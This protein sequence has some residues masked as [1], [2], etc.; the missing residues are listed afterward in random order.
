MY[1][2]HKQKRE[3]RKAIDIDGMLKRVKQRAVELNQCAERILTEK[4][5]QTHKT[6][7]Q[8]QTE[9]HVVRST[10]VDIKVTAEDILDSAKQTG[11][12][13]RFLGV[14]ANQ[15][16]R[17]F[18]TNMRGQSN[19]LDRLGQRLEQDLQAI[20][21]ESK[22]LMDSVTAQNLVLKAFADV[23]NGRLHPAMLLVATVA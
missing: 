9:L 12:D 3:R 11:S 4:T 5:L 2:R 17:N 20:N 15:F 7:G 14:A 1:E 22:R 16:A 8:M 10:A 21:M 6:A 18:D 13:V 19:K 23:L